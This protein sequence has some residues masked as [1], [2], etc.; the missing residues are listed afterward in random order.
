LENQTGLND[1]AS[2]LV[3]KL[4]VQREQLTK[5]RV[6]Y[7]AQH[8]DVKK[9]QQSVA[10]L[11]RELRNI[12]I[13]RSASVIVAPTKPDNPTY[14]S[15]QTQLNSVTADIFADQSTRRKLEQ[16]LEKYESR[17]ASAPGVERDFLELNRDYDNAKK[18]YQEIKDKLLESRMAEQLEAGGKSERFSLVERP[19][20]PTV[21][22]KPNRFGI[23]LLGSVMAFAFGLGG[24]TVREYSDH[25]VSGSKGVSAISHA[26]PLVS[27]PYIANSQDMRSERWR[28]WR[29]IVLWFIAI[30][31]VSASFIL[32]F[33][34]KQ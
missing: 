7:S 13:D 4:S 33:M 22:E 29:A 15:L 24:V 19:Y 2:S 28:R 23:A 25:T 34:F 11:E 14:V 27:I 31:M 20:T 26:P 12:S 6:R 21:P 32:L 30:L 9:L 16:K 3:A 18:K 5:A 8:P 10:S 1:S 17:L